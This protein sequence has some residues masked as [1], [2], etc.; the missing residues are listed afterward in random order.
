M[1]ST[2]GFYDEVA[3]V[4]TNMYIREPFRYVSLMSLTNRSKFTKEM[5][6]EWFFDLD[7]YNKCITLVK[8]FSLH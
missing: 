3:S 5:L 8:A 2:L 1:E 7:T 6:E 4:F